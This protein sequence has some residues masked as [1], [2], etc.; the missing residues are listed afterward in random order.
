MKC[1]FKFTNLIVSISLCILTLSLF[2]SPVYALDYTKRDL[3]EADFSG[4]NLVGSTFNKTNLRSS[5]FS[6]ANLENVSFF[7]AN[8]D[9]A[10]LENANLR[11]AIFDTARLTKAN[12]KNAILEGAFATNTKFEGANIEGADFTDVLLRPD[13]EDLLCN[14]AS[15]TNPVTGRNTKDTLFCP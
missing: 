14:L 8:L 2:I 12:L 15:G 4:Q 6:N 13:V 9:S 3:R 11:G 1:Y 10:N 5:N 7:G